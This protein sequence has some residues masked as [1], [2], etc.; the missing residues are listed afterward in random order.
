M[1][2]L[3]VCTLALESLISSLLLILYCSSN[4]F[5]MPSRAAI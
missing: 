4:L 3:L 5:S 2:K 1:Y